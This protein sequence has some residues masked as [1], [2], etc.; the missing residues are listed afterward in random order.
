MLPGKRAV[1]VGD[2]VLRE[3]ATLLIEKVKDPRVKGVT[4]TGV[5]LS[6]DLKRARIFFSVVGDQIRIDEARAGLNSARGF[7]KREV[8]MRMELRYVPEISFAHD[9]SLETGSHME[10]V[11][12]KIRRSEKES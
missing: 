2:L 10:R 8:G 3:I 5:R 12:A 7:I 6:N 11:F 1:R 9:P 4:L